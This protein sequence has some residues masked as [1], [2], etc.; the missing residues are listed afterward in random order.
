MP[1]EDKVI[2]LARAGGSV[3]LP[4]DFWLVAAANP[5]PC[6]NLGHPSRPCLCSAEMRERYVARLDSPLL[7][8]AL[9]IDLAPVPAATLRASERGMFD[10]ATLRAL[11]AA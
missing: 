2:T 11:V 7:R 5:C 4:A 6:G 1:V 9:R 10:T 3:K 8:G